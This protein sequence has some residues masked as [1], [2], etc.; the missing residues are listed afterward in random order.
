[1][2]QLDLTSVYAALRQLQIAVDGVAS[3]CLQT[4]VPADDAVGVACAVIADG[5]VSSAEPDRDETV[6]SLCMAL[7]EV[8]EAL[9]DT[10]IE[11]GDREIDLPPVIRPPH[12]HR[13]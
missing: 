13:A 12:G 1:M 11:G 3:D 5:I 9:E 7:R 2:P 10:P 8:L 6:A 4:D